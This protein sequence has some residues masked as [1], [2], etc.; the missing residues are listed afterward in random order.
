MSLKDLPV[1]RIVSRI[2]SKE[3]T[4]DEV[5]E[6][7][8]ERINKFNHSLNAIVS[9]RNEEEIRE[10]ARNKKLHKT[11]EGKEM[12]L[13]GLPLAVKDL[14]DVKGLPTSYGLP[15]LKSNIATQ[16]SIMVSRLIN[17]GAI[18]IGKTNTPEFGVGSH[19]TNKLFGVTAN[20]FDP[21]KSAG[22]SSGGAASAV[23]SS[24]VPFADGSDMMGSCRNPAAYANLY[25]FRPTPGLIPEKRDFKPEKTSPVLS[26]LGCLAKTP[27]DTALFLDVVSGEDSADPFSFNI[28]SSFRGCR[29]KDEEFLN[30]RLGW[31]SDLI[32]TYKIDPTIIDM[33][34]KMLHNLEKMKI[35]VIHQGSKIKA[36]DLWNSWT[37]L[38][39][40]N[41]FDDLNEVN[42]QNSEELGFP[43]KWEYA[44]GKEVNS[45]NIDLA[46]SQRIDCM[47]K[48]DELFKN[49]D[50]LVMPSAQI[51]PFNK[52]LD[53]PKEICGNSLDTY[54]R[55]M[56]VVILVSLLGLP[57]ISVPI[58]FNSEGLP[59]GMQ[60]VGKRG[61]DLKVVA[62]AKKYEEIFT[63][64]KQGY[65]L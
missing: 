2:I 58:G 20:V 5:V 30:L 48:V 40:K 11:K 62:F 15:E 44:R 16:N 12:L 1:E 37:T 39:A 36:E 17:H 19:T 41:N 18:I 56:E 33:C 21:T 43:V 31:L 47:N 13:F 53:Y 35:Q 59:M 14:V 64:S 27:D 23:A 54:H 25:G 4:V 9:L 34:E 26:T 22:G 38:R 65:K 52:E 6:Y 7:Y 46:L 45:N 3:I 24:M 60:I 57:S 29:I 32:G 42:L 28:L 8:L 55:W 10:E 63:F 61:D 51:F 49:L 50:F